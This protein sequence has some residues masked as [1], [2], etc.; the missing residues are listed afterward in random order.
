[1]ATFRFARSRARGSASSRATCS[2]SAQTEAQG[3]AADLPPAADVVEEVGGQEGRMVA[4]AEAGCGGVQLGSGVE[5]TG[6]SFASLRR[7]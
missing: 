5:G 4:L 6:T 7:F 2:R 1:L 3:G